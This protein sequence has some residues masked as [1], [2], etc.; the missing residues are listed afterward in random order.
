MAHG[1]REA[2]AKLV[3]AMTRLKRATAKRRAELPGTQARDDALVAEERVNREVFDL[4]RQ[5]EE[6]E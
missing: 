3:D 6:R 1:D 2:T 5:P 4:A